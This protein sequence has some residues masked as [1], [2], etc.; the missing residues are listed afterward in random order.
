MSSTDSKQQRTLRKGSVT[1]AFVQHQR[2]LK[3][4]I[5][6][7]IHDSHEI[8]DVSQEAYLR[9]FVA[10]KE[11]AIEQPK[12]FLFRI[13][14]NLAMTTLTKKSRRLTDFIE[15]SESPDVV[16]QEQAVES[17]VIASQSVA[18]HCEAVAELSPQR[19][20]VY[21]LRKVYGKSHKEIAAHLDITVSTV[22]KHLIKAT[23]QCDLYIREKQQFYTGNG[24]DN[25]NAG[26]TESVQAGS[27]Q[28]PSRGR[29]Q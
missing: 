1:G 7:F 24:M 3:R 13:A 23:R 27:V 18:I 29:V 16:G 19:R 8:E 5:A 4:Y 2:A 15:D 14:H 12:S 6:R 26:A 22:E 21:L 11:R 28:A 25:V 20:R 10:E 9:A 17:E